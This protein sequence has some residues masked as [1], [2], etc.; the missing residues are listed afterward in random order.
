MKKSTKIEAWHILVL[1][2]SLKCLLRSSIFFG[3][4]VV[5]CWRSC[6][7]Q[8][9]LLALSLCAYSYSRPHSPP[10]Q[11]NVPCT[12]LF[13]TS[14]MPLPLSGLNRTNA[15]Q[16]PP[17]PASRLS[18]KAHFLPLLLLSSSLLPCLPSLALPTHHTDNHGSTTPPR[19]TFH[20]PGHGQRLLCGPATG[21]KGGREGRKTG[22]G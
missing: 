1:S 9:C 3:T 13:S 6:S 4:G 11:L 7:C 19:A 10:A 17:P 18:R 21:K 16:F 14:R 12:T 20:V 5:F 2:F 15:R 22:G 8:R